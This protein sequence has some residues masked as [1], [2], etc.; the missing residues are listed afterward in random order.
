M[1]HKGVEFSLE[2]AEHGLWTYRFKIG[3]RVK[4][5]RTRANLQ[6]LAERRVRHRIDR[7]LRLAQSRS[8]LPGLKS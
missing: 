4:A 6:L 5:G 8:S 2:Q 3:N 1:Q 7:E